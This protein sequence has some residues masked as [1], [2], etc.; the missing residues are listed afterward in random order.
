MD[1]M[2][3]PDRKDRP[4]LRA[5]MARTAIR[6]AQARMADRVLTE[7]RASGVP[8]GHAVP[9]ARLG[10]LDPPVSPVQPVRRVRPA[11]LAR[12]AR[13]ANGARRVSRVLRAILARL[14]RRAN[15]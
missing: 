14:V 6:D 13:R 3:W 1:A 15:L 5:S 2:E 10:R 8:T 4:G 7:I 11:Y 12:A 9:M